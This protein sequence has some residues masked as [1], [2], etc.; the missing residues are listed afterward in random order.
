MIDRTERAECCRSTYHAGSNP[1]ALTFLTGGNNPVSDVSQ[2]TNVPHVAPVAT[3][4]RVSFTGPRHDTV[5]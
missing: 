3:L 1:A 5:Q 2:Q 4:R